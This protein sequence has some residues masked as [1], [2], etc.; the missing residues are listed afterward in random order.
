[1]KRKKQKAQLSSLSRLSLKS[2]LP[3]DM[4]T[5]LP[6]IKM[7]SNRE[8]YIEDAGQILRYDSECVVIFQRKMLLTIGGK[9]LHLKSLADKNVSVEGIIEYISFNCGERKE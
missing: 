8:I 4:L 9:N 1:M 5:N 2:G 7:F 3:L 6:L